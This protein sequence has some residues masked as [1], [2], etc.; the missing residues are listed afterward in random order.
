VQL[1]F[2]DELSA[3]VLKSFAAEVRSK[4]TDAIDIWRC[5]EVAFAAGVDAAEFADGVPARSAAIIRSLFGTR[6]GGGMTALVA[7]QRLSDRAAD[8]RFTR[9][10]A[11]IARVVGT[12]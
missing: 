3:L 8:A 6:H 5:L 12:N 2:A 9:L 4:A 7:E 1:A 11:L 10:R